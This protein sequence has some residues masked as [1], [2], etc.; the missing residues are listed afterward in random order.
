MSWREHLLTAFVLTHVVVLV[1]WTWPEPGRAMKRAQAVVRPYV[2]A[3]S[4]GQSWNM[5]APS[6]PRHN[7][8]FVAELVLADG[9][10]VTWSPLQGSNEAWW[11]SWFMERERKLVESLGPGKDARLYRH[12]LDFVAKR[13]APA[14]AVIVGRS[15]TRYQ[16]RIMLPDSPVVEGELGVELYQDGTRPKTP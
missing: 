12:Y 13:V 10:V 2:T 16:T 11:R 1:V 4:L 6:P 3:A 5:F 9:Q 7:T 8:R 15:L 14:G